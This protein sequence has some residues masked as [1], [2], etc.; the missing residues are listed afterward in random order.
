ME[1]LSEV[2]YNILIAIQLFK[3]RQNPVAKARIYGFCDRILSE[4]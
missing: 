1:D 2:M 4:F 3:F